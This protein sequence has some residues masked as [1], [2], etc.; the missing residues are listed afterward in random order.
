MNTVRNIHIKVTMYGHQVDGADNPDLIGSE[1]RCLSYPGYSGRGKTEG[2]AIEDLLAN[3]GVDYDD[4]GPVSHV[5]HVH[6]VPSKSAVDAVNMARARGEGTPARPAHRGAS[7]P[8]LS[9]V[10]PRVQHG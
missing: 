6:V 5:Y 1:C 9:V 10:L 3:L 2:E 4:L 8:Y 7:C